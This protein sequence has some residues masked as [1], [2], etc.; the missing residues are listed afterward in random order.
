MS[1]KIF[2]IGGGVSKSIKI[3]ST[4]T[5]EA[6]GQCLQI[7]LPVTITNQECTPK[8][9]KKFT[10]TN[11][12]DIGTDIKTIELT[13]PKDD[14]CGLTT[15]QIEKYGWKNCS[16]DVPP[17]TTQTRDLDIQSSQS[18][19][20]DI[21]PTIAGITIGPTAVLTLTKE[22]DYSYKLVGPHNYIAYFPK[23]S[24]AYY[25]SYK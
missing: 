2:G 9:G 23:N 4:D 6:S 3:V 12:K 21:E 7:R 19:T 10:R 13:D 25:W 18:A 8:K 14:K 1:I 24:I 15:S 22:I 11:I 20:L 16:I 5:I 17:N